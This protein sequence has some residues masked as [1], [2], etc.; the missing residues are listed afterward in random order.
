MA[1]STSW[2]N[3]ALD[4]CGVIALCEII[5]SPAQFVSSTPHY[6]VQQLDWIQ[7]R[8]LMVAKRSDSATAMDDW[9]SGEVNQ[10]QP[11][12]VAQD[13]LRPVKGPRVSNVLNIPLSALPSSRS[14][15]QASGASKRPLAALEASSEPD[16]EDISDLEALSTVEVVQ[17]PMKRRLIARSRALSMDADTAHQATTHR[18][19]TP[20]MTDFTPGSL[21]LRS[22][23]RLALPQW[24]DAKSTKRLTNDIKQLQ[25]VY[26]TTPLHELGWYID[27]D[28]IENMF[29]WIVELHSFNPELPLAKDMKA[30]GVR[31][32]ILEVRFG[33][34]YP[35]SPPFVRVI[36]PRFLPFMSGGGGHVTIGGAL[37][38][39]LLTSNGWSPATSMEAVFVCIKL[40]MSSTDPRP[41][42]LESAVMGSGSSAGALKDYP[43]MAA[44]VAFER[45][46]RTHGWTVP[47]DVHANASQAY[48]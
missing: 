38:M 22:L 46:A 5:N 8:Y 35:M 2:P 27:F 21:D 20:P 37:C 44:L 3:S 39:E 9:A 45:A 42:R 36:R 4:A 19:P 33:R 32:V 28:N 41:A 14:A 6:V 16:E 34:D 7:C 11:N 40:A 15:Q 31:S 47:Q 30:A 12:Y 48:E 18:P 1:A 43:A 13:P 29:Q 25:T 24:A 10:D 26:A 23:P 17:P